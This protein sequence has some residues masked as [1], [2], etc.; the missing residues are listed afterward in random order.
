MLITEIEELMD[1]ELR[2][3]VSLSQYSCA[4]GL[5]YKRYGELYIN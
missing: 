1:D 5:I 3:K 2:I 4:T